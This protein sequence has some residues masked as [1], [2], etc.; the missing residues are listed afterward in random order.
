MSTL[1]PDSKSSFTT[2]TCPSCAAIHNGLAWS[3]VKML[4]KY[5]ILNFDKCTSE[6]NRKSRIRA[7]N[8]YMARVTVGFE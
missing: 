3:Y 5:S 2:A 6:K 7:L 1:A 4:G 8:R